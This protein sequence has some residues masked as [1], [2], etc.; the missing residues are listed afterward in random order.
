MKNL[1]VWVELT[2]LIIPGLNDGDQELGDIARFVK[3][4]GPEVPWHV[5]QFHPAYKYL[6]RS[7]TPVSTLRRARQIGRN[8]GLRYVYE[9]NVPGEGGENTFCYA[10]G[11]VLIERFGVKILKNRV[12]GGTCPECGTM[13]DGFGI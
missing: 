6:D 9:G 3:S 10:C 8:E 12:R 13:I 4:V 2:T 1:G 5:T 11:A 7:P